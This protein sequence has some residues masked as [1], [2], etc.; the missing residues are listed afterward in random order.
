MSL[1]NY[2]ANKGIAGAISQDLCHKYLK[3]K[4]QN[5]AEGELSLL[6]IVWNN[7]LTLNEIPIRN[8]DNDIDKITRLEIIKEQHNKSNSL[9]QFKTPNSLMDLFFDILYIETD[10]LMTK[11]ASLSKKLLRLFADNAKKFGLDYEEEYKAKRFVM[12]KMRF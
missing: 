10:I 3:A 1:F 12:E 8:E 4:N 2:L 11:D 9:C 5:P 6:E 7:W